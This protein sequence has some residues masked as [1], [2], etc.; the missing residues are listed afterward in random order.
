M[1]YIQEPS[2]AIDVVQPLVHHRRQDSANANNA[3]H[4]RVPVFF[5]DTVDFGVETTGN[6]TNTTITPMIDNTA[7]VYIPIRL[8]C[9]VQVLCAPEVLSG[10]PMVLRSLQTDLVHSLKVLPWS[11][12]NVVRRIQIWVNATYAYG[13]RDDPRVLRHSTAHHQEGWLIHWYV[14]CCFVGVKGVRSAE[15]CVWNLISG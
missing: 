3:K 15:F 12:H 11:V 8:P 13:S 14:T 7:L 10:C 6:N 5:E 4:V 1:V 9:G 2:N